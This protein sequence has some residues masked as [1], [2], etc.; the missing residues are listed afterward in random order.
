M[1]AT[2]RKP[3]LAA[4]NIAEA[5]PRRPVLVVPGARIQLLAAMTEQKVYEETEYEEVSCNYADNLGH[6]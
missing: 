6:K 2:L 4:D 3:L 5:D 1:G